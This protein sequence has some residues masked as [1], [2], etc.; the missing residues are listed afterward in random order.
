MKICIYGG[1]NLGHV[2]AGYLA[3][4]REHE[5]IDNN[6]VLIGLIVISIQ[7]LVCL[8]LLFI[9][10]GKESFFIRFEVHL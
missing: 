2:M 6:V 10:L 9:K 3:A 5:I 7:I 1:G 8:A 4:K